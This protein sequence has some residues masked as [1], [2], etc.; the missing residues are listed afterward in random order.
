VP[1][2]GRQLD[3][4]GGGAPLPVCVFTCVL[5]EFL[6]FYHF[7]PVL[8]CV[9]ASTSDCLVFMYLPLRL[10]VS[11]PL[12]VSLSPITLSIPYI[13]CDFICHVCYMWNPHVLANKTTYFWNLVSGAV[14]QRTCVLDNC[15]EFID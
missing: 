6:L 12:L 4:L 10:L 14:S 9:C 7:D 1:T 2:A 3:P 5:L 8:L 15:F 11:F 13:Q